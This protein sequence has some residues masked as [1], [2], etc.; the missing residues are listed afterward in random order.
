MGLLWAEHLVKDG[1]KVVLW[2]L[3]GAELERAAGHIRGLGGEVLTQV[4]DVTD[5]QAVYAAAK[6]AAS[7]TGSIEILINNAGI[8]AAG[9]FLEMPDEKLDATID[10]DVKALLW[11]MKA[12]LPA[13]LERGAGH[14]INIS[15]ASGF[16]GVPYMP[17]YAASK[18]AVIGMTESLRLEMELE[19]H[20][21]IKF[22]LF[23]P[24]YVDTGMFAGVKP[25]L[26][27]PILTPEIAVKRAYKGFRKGE[28]LILEPFIVK[29]T[30][31]L[32]ALLPRSIFDRVSDVLG[33]TQSAKGVHGRK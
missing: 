28:Y 27:A 33:V 22:T 16:I 17:A 24:S 4:V 18:W 12:F 7:K 20:T 10:V 6:D 3:D 26:L 15:S 13:M 31:A 8:V 30:P 9:K 19:G 5:R 1:A 25:P 29:F 21:G 11:T 32:K 2:D 14:I 23:C